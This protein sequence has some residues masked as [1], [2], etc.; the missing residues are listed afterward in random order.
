[1]NSAPSLYCQGRRLTQTLINSDNLLL[2]VQ[3]HNIHPII[4]FDVD[5]SSFANQIF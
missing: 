3:L 1:M 5:I 2:I 4:G